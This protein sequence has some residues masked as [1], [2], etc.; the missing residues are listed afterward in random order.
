MPLNNVKNNIQRR[1]KYAKFDFIIENIEFELLTAFHRNSIQH[2]EL[3]Q[4]TH[5]NVIG[6]WRGSIITQE[7]LDRF[8]S[9]FGELSRARG[10]ISTWV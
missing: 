9:K 7:P 6:G 1:L 10:M 8:A 4:R 3:D 2:G 5:Y